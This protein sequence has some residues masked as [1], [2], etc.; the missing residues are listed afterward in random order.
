MPQ[1]GRGL[2]MLLVRKPGTREEGGLGPLSCSLAIHCP[3]GQVPLRGEGDMLPN[4]GGILGNE[5]F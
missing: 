1:A 5:E 4:T 3:N 2:G